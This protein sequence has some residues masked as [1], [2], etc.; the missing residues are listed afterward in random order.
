[1]N[2]PRQKI[3]ELIE[4]CR[5]SFSKIGTFSQRYMSEHNKYLEENTKDSTFIKQKMKEKVA[6]V[7]DE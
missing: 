1:M 2:D 6:K 3:L 7:V 5:D 4:L